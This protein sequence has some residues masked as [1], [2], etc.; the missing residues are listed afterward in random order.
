[1]VNHTSSA[2]ARSGDLNGTSQPLALHWCS[3]RVHLLS[4][5]T[6]SPH[7]HGTL[8]H[9]PATSTPS[10]SHVSIFTLSTQTVQLCAVNHALAAS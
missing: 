1:M 6:A 4:V 10:Q 8:G 3:L 2:E 9:L 7:F 5:A